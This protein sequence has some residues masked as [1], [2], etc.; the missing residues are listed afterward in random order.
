MQV[1]KVKEAIAVAQAFVQ[2]AEEILQQAG[3]TTNFLLTDG[4]HAKIMKKQ[5]M[6]VINAM[7]EMRRP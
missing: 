7:Q 4:K 3:S 5:S 6:K 2:R 1:A